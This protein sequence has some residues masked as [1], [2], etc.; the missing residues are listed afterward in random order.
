[1]VEKCSR[2]E[3]IK[4]N[5]I[6]ILQFD[7]FYKE[8]FNSDKLKLMFFGNYFSFR[9]DILY[10]LWSEGYIKDAITRIFENKCEGLLKI[11]A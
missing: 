4:Q 5:H 6:L 1:L 10:E 2:K 7:N 8:Y 3:Y 11:L 9:R